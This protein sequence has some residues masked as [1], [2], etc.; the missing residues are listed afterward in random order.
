MSQ[1]YTHLTSLTDSYISTGSLKQKSLKRKKIG[2]EN[3]DSNFI[4]ARESRKI[5]KVRQ[6][7]A[8]EEQLQHEQNLAASEKFPTQNTLDGITLEAAEGFSDAFDDEDEWEDDAGDQIDEEVPNKAYL[9][10]I[11]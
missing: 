5:L 7:L 3:P 2:D 9:R 6:E 8:E 10:D 11:T 4:D 1:K